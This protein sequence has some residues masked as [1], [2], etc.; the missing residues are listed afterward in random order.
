M[1]EFTRNI[2][3]TIECLAY[4]TPQRFCAKNLLKGGRR[5]EKVVK[6]GPP[7]QPVVISLPFKFS[8]FAWKT[9][10]SIVVN[11]STFRRQLG[12]T[13]TYRYENWW[14]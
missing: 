13:A 2:L 12:T 8:S 7:S 6:V 14:K 11:E 9:V 3:A 1:F 4:V 10:V 5:Y